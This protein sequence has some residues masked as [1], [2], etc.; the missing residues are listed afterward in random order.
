M[1]SGFLPSGFVERMT[2]D[3]TI[4]TKE[5]KTP[6]QNTLSLNN[7]KYMNSG[8]FCIYEYFDNTKYISVMD[9]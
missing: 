1:R 8:F 3:F 6:S 9:I 5:S 4:V 2:L 7:T